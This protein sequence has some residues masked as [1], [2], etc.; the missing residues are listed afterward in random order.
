MKKEFKSEDILNEKT[1]RLSEVNSLLDIKEKED[2]FIE[3]IDDEIN[4][5]D[6]NKDRDR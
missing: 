4:K 6:P 5:P 1:K 3:D 2:D